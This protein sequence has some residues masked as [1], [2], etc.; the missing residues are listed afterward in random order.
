MLII[1][2][3]PGE[4]IRIELHPAV[5]PNMTVA[6]LFANG[7]I[8]LRFLSMKGPNLRIGINASQSLLILREE[9]PTRKPTTVE[10]PTQT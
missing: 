7:P 10:T 4:G 8:Q 1:T 6:E 2:R 9:L 3:R 5:D